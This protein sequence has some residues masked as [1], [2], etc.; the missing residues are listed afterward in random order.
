VDVVK[1][2]GAKLPKWLLAGVFAGFVFQ[3]LFYSDHFKNQLTYWQ[4]VVQ[5]QP[6]LSG[7]HLNLGDAY[8]GIRDYQKA[9]E[10]YLAALRINPVEGMAHNNLAVLYMNTNRMSEAAENL[11]KELAQ[12]PNYAPSY[13]YL[14]LLASKSGDVASAEMHWKRA[15]DLDP[16][17]FVVYRHLITLYIDQKRLL[18]AKPLVQTMRKSGED[19]PEWVMKA[20]TI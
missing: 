12:S 15:L 8:Q 6:Q 3:T 18:D 4:T 11:K 5:N 9:E 16:N 14:G 17:L 1:V 13:Y 19:V 10:Q 7:P 20:V 2:F